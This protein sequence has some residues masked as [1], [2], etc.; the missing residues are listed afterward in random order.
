MEL[1]EVT[2]KEYK[3]I[4]SKS[5]KHGLVFNAENYNYLKDNDKVHWEFLDYT[6]YLSQKDVG[7]SFTEGANNLVDKVEFFLKL[8]EVIY[9]DEKGFENA[10]FK[11]GEWNFS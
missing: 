5:R 6:S 4:T 7:I 2:L 3:E 11:D 10:E 1:Q 8:E 9:E